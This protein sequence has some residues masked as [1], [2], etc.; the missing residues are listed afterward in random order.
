MSQVNC[1]EVTPS[2]N[3]LTCNNHD[4]VP[5]PSTSWQFN[6]NDYTAGLTPGVYTYTYEVVVGSV[7]KEFNVDLNFVDVCKDVKIVKPSETTHVYF[8]TD[9]TKQIE[10]MPPFS[11]DPSF[12]EYAIDGPDSEIPGNLTPEPCLNNESCI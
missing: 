12:C 3:I 7:V 9:P 1:K 4:L 10:L 2:T 8:I 6:G 5:A 11:V